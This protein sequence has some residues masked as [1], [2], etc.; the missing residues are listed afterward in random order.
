MKNIKSF[1]RQISLAGFLW[2]PVVLAQAL[3][4]GTAVTLGTLQI[5]ITQIANFLIIVGGI[6]AV[7]AIL[8]SGIKYMMAGD[9]TA[10][11]KSAQEGL[12]T[13]IIGTF[14]VLGLGVILST[15]AYIVRY[16]TFQ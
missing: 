13:A 3:P 7:I 9:D 8:V 1:I 4:A 6:I 15:V 10:K 16:Q 2:A 12:K 14:V 5:L 11:V